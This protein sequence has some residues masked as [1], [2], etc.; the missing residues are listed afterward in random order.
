MIDPVVAE[1]DD[2]LRWDTF[3]EGRL[4]KV[5][6]HSRQRCFQFC[7]SDEGRADID[8]HGSWGVAKLGSKVQRPIAVVL[9]R[10]RV[11]SDC[12]SK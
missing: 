2:V 11:Y 7:L 9:I 8:L 3:D 4:I 10:G 1:S 12:G 6:G 5:D